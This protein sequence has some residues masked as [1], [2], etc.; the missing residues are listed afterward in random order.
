[1]Y[2]FTSQGPNFAWHC[3]G[4]DKLKPFG[5]PIHG[6]IDGYN[7]SMKLNFQK[8]SCV[9]VIWKQ[10]YWNIFILYRFSRRIMWLKVASSNNNPKF[11]A[12]YYFECVRKVGGMCIII[13]MLIVIIIS[14]F[15]SITTLQWMLLLVPTYILP[16]ITIQCV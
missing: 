1:M 13:I 10:Y 12:S 2:L 4:Y 8:S 3:D 14:A 9:H 7:N 11:I 15:N 5:L 16:S 6:C